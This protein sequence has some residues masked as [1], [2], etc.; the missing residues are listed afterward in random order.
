MNGSPIV[1]LNGPPHA[2]KS[3]VADYL[4]RRHGFTY[5]GIS[6]P[7][8]NMLRALGLTDEELTGA[9]KEEPCE[10]LGGK[11][12]RWGQQTLGKDWRDLVHPDLWLIVWE[13]TR[14]PG[15]LVLDDLRFPNDEAF[16]RKRGAKILRIE[17]PGLHVRDTGHEAE[18]QKISV[19]ARI[20]NGGTI[21]DLEII[22]AEC[23]K[24]LG[25]PL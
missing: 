18:K 23:L 5:H 2:G 16:F 7:I 20:T 4:V 3:T 25:V 8:K 24:A 15:P 6:I 13:K 9:L 1:A 14:P 22:V 10:L 21:A 19:D 12:P 17:R 11:S